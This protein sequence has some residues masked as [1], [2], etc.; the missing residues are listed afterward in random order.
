MDF[1]L[2]LPHDLLEVFDHP[3]KVGPADFVAEQ[4][5]R[6]EGQRNDGKGGAPVSRGRHLQMHSDAIFR[7]F[8]KHEFCVL[9]LRISGE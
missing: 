4:E 9:I 2:Q 7:E 8:T 6:E 3:R 1:I 5:T